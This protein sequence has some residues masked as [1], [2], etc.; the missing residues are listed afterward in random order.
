MTL[1]QQIL[2]WIIISVVMV[3]FIYVFRAILLPFVAG[4]GLAYLLDPLADRLQK[5]RFSRMWATITILLIFV[6]LFALL[7]VIVAPIVG[8]QLIGLVAKLPEYATG[9]QT[10]LVEQAQ[11]LFGGDMAN[12]AQMLKDSVG[13][14]VGQGAKWI[15]SILTSLWNGG[16]A[17]MSLLGLLIV[18]PVVAFY[19]LLDWDRMVGKI[20]GWLPRDHVETV[21]GLAR[22]M[23]EAVAG[24]VRGQVSVCLI[25]GIYYAVTLTL[26]GVNFGA[27]I[28]LG[29]G[30]FSFIP[31][32]GAIIGFILAVGVALVQFWPDWVWIVATIVVFL[33]GQ[34]LEGNILSPNLVGSKVGLH[35]V[36]LMFALFA[37]GYLFGFVGMLVAV[38]AAAIVAVLVRFMIRQY[39]ESKLYAGSDGG[40]DGKL[41]AAKEAE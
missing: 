15:G 21:R 31:Y 11:K 41:E 26:I 16:Q 4:M 6:F 30:I 20:D 27:A 39:L 33:F 3:L 12:S 8:H 19:M 37:F 35:P 1:K 10:I 22:E 17:L 25:L 9:I 29:A 23:N 38:P 18:T 14:L 36:W 2:A 24:F 5:L 28:G 32:V 7:L 13:N 40:G 34:F